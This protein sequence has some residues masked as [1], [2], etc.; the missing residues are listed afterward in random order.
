MLDAHIK[1]TNPPVTCKCYQSFDY[2]HSTQNDNNGKRSISLSFRYQILT[3][4]LLEP[5]FHSAKCKRW[6]WQ[7]INNKL[8]WK[9][10]SRDRRFLLYINKK[11]QRPFIP[12]KIPNLH[13]ALFENSYYLTFSLYY[14]LIISH[15]YYLTILSLKLFM[16]LENWYFS[17]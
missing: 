6:G 11:V 14:L 3:S 12:H 17:K 13:E 10:F 2:R 9:T 5:R 15:Y 7:F 16:I 8:L 1:K 4:Y